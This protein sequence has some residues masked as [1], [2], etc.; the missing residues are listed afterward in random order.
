VLALTLKKRLD[1]LEAATAKSASES[2]ATIH[3]IVQPSA[4]GPELAGLM[5]RPPDGGNAV[6]TDRATGE[7]D[8]VLRA[9][10]A[11]MC[12]DNQRMKGAY[13]GGL[14]CQTF[15]FSP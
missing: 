13:L 3:A 14:N 7:S 4:T 5:L 12:S 15:D 9:R 10:F 8:A 2:R 11:E 6:R 1:R